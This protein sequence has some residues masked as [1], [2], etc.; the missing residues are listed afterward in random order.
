MFYAAMLHSPVETLDGLI[1]KLNSLAHRSNVVLTDLHTSLEDITRLEHDATTFDPE[2]AAWAH[3]Q[4]AEWQPE[5]IC[6]IDEERSSLSPGRHFWPGE[7]HMYTDCKPTPSLDTYVL[8]SSV[9]VSTVWNTYRKARMMLLDIIV[10]CRKRLTKTP[11]TSKE[12]SEAQRLGEAIAATVPFHLVHD[13]SKTIVQ[14]DTKM[15]TTKC[16]KPVGG[17]LLIHA[18]YVSAR[19][20]IVSPRLKKYMCDQL[21][22]IGQNMGIGQATLLA[23]VRIKDLLNMRW[24]ADVI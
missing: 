16:A 5:V 8:I 13:L 3:C 4:P 1:V 19:L 9:Y 10:Q 18:L 14:D 23:D 24:K 7:V 17:L 20:P 22:W 12:E 11:N 6:L 21:Q 2:F 15:R